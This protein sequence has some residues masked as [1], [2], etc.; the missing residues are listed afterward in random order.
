[1]RIYNKLGHTCYFPYAGS[2]RRG[3]NLKTQEQSPDLPIERVNHPSLRNDLKRGRIGVMLSP[4]DKASLR[5]I[6]DAETMALLEG[7]KKP[8]KPEAPTEPLG[9]QMDARPPKQDDK[10]DEADKTYEAGAEKET[11]DPVKEELAAKTEMMSEEG[12]KE[13]LDKLAESDQPSV[14]K[15]AEELKEEG[16]EDDQSGDEDTGAADSDS[17]TEASD[18]TEP[19]ADEDAGDSGSD[20]ADESAPAG[21]SGGDDDTAKQ[22]TYK[23]IAKAKLLSLCLERELDANPGMKV[24][25]MRDL[26]VA[27]DQKKAQG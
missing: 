15:A 19:A 26:L 4:A 27:D 13:E 10:K 11:V 7:A 24:K 20:A 2:G 23:G 22:K 6:V 5:S 3:V 18:E 25:E 1:M 8:E 16:G 21:E 9:K 17:A 14:A 12:K